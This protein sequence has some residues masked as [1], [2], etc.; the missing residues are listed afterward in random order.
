MISEAARWDGGV[1][2][3][4]MRAAEEELRRRRERGKQSQARFRKRQAE[5]AQET[6]AQ[7]EKMKTAI[8]AIV[9]AAQRS[10]QNGVLEAVRAAADVAGVDGLGLNQETSGEDLKS[11]DGNVRHS[12]LVKDSRQSTSSNMQHLRLKIP[13]NQAHSNSAKPWSR[14]ILAGCLSP[15]LDYGIWIDTPKPPAY[16]MP[17]IGEGRYTFRGHLYWACTD[18]LIALCR[19]ITT[20]HSQ[21]LWF[22]GQPGSC[23]TPQEAE[24]RVWTHI[25]HWPPVENVPM[26]QSMAEKQVYYRDC[27]YSDN[28]A[29]NEELGTCPLGH[30]IGDPNIWMSITDLERHRCLFRLERTIAVC[31]VKQSTKAMSEDL[32]SV[33][34]LLMKNLAESFIC[35]GDGPRWRTDAVSTLFKD[36]MRM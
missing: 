36:A 5:A 29:C 19:V 33:V 30:P 13:M 34:R 17:F 23:P 31:C 27:G 21:S 28:A 15:R 35:F 10:D 24:D 9:R 1:N 11:G 26:L 14:D 7:N 2:E 6:R 25:R 32:V 3:S 8:A 16:I 18:Y 22:G 12:S 4:A 20:P